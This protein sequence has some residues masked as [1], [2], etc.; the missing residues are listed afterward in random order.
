[1]KTTFFKRAVAGLVLSGGL[2]MAAPSIAAADTLVYQGK[3]SGMYKYVNV[4]TNSTIMSHAFLGNVYE[5][6][7][8]S[9]EAIR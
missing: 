1:M 6:K 7:Q 3:S 9:Q 2:L 8:C 4:Q 5:T